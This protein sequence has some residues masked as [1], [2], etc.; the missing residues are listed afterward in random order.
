MMFNPTSVCA[1]IN[2]PQATFQEWTILIDLTDV[3]HAQRWLEVKFSFQ[4]VIIDRAASPAVRNLS[5]CRTHY[6]GMRLVIES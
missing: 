4:S 6:I 1:A 3:V 5:L 2:V